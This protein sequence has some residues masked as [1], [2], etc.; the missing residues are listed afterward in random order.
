[1][2]KDPL[3]VYENFYYLIENHLPNHFLVL[4]L[5]QANFQVCELSP[6][7][8]ILLNYAREV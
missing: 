8:P 3:E 7:Q 4:A 1:M 2:V 6:E 5:F